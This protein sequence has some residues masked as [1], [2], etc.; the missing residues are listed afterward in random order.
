MEAA[1]SSPSSTKMDGMPRSNFAVDRMAIAVARKIELE[2]LIKRNLEKEHQEILELETAV[3]KLESPHEKMVIRMK[4]F[5]RIE[6]PE[7]CKAI[8]GKH[9]DYEEKQESYMRRTFRLHGTALVKL[10]EMQE[11]HIDEKGQ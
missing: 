11:D 8:F 7:I 4:Y 5:D 2:E 1:I 9:K 10:S 6:W 3:Q